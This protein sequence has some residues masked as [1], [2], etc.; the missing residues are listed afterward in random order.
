[1]E[2]WRK[3]VVIVLLQCIESF[4]PARNVLEAIVYWHD[5]PRTA[6]ECVHGNYL[7]QVA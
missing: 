7:A 3:L 2:I 6:V 5:Q 1:M 4:P